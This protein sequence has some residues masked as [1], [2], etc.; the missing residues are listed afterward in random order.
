[1]TQIASFNIP[2]TEEEQK[3]INT[4]LLSHSIEK[5]EDIYV[6]EQHITVLYENNNDDTYSNQ[7]KITAVRAILKATEKEIFKYE[8]EIT[9]L[10]FDLEATVGSDE[11]KKAIQNSID[12][13]VRFKAVSEKKAEYLRKILAGLM[14]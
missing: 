8:I 5:K 3:I 2:K 7:D 1:M 6:G 13:N 9:S 4:F 10:C 12:Q 11:S 14:N